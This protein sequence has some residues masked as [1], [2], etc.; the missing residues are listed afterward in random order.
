MAPCKLTVV[1]A[2]VASLLLQQQHQGNDGA[3]S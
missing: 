2:L 3:T 1:V